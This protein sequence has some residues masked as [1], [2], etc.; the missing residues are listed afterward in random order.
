MFFDGLRNI[1]DL[2]DFFIVFCPCFLHG[3]HGHS[4]LVVSVGAG[5]GEVT[6]SAFAGAGGGRAVDV[7]VF[8]DWAVEVG[9]FVAVVVAAVGDGDCGVVVRLVGVGLLVVAS[10][11]TVGLDAETCAGGQESVLIGE[12]VVGLADVLG[13]EGG[14]ALGVGAGFR[15]FAGWVQHLSLAH[16][17]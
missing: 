9:E 15:V 14:A 4:F 3:D 7:G 2:M 8:V 13:V 6:D 11:G 10:I 12:V 17:Q 1:V 16:F 5:V